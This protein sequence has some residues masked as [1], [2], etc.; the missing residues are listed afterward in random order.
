M[1]PGSPRFRNVLNESVLAADYYAMAE[2]IAGPF[3]PMC[4][5]LQAVRDSGEP[6]AEDRPVVP[7]GLATA[8][9]KVRVTAATEMDEYV[10]KQRNA[11]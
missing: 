4:C 6:T 5:T 2:Q 7:I 11:W 10:L 9:P 1:S 3:G 8:T